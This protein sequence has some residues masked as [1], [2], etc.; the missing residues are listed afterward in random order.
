M[1]NVVLLV[2]TG[3]I[4]YKVKVIKEEVKQIKSI[5]LWQYGGD[6]ELA[7]SFF[8]SEQFK[9]QAQEGIK[10]ALKSMGIELSGS[11]APSEAQPPE[12]AQVEPQ[13][14][15]AQNEPRPNPK[16]LVELKPS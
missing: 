13:P 7:K 15:E 16:D 12:Q 9:K 5:V 2:L 6:Y 3:F 11:E 8:E 1:L 4:L 10:Q 14:Q